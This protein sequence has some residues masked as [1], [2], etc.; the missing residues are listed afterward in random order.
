MSTPLPDSPAAERNK[1]PI[2]E[3]LRQ[4]LPASGAVLEIA[5]GTGQHVVHFAAAFPA[6]SWQ[7]TDPD[8][9]C[10]LAT[11]TRCDSAHLKNIHAP[12]QLDVHQATWPVADDFDAVLCINM[13]H[14][15]PWSATA[16]LLAGAARV[17]RGDGP[18]LVLLYG[19]YK[20]GGRHTAPSNEAFDASLRS[21]DPRWGVRDLE[22]VAEVAGSCGFALHAVHRLPANNLFV[23]LRGSA[24][25]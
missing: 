2:L 16:A 19:P 21:R 18:R 17:L 13:I 8:P 25:A 11:A 10:V 14:I 3:E 1:T 7:P 24:H 15:A 22:A 20:E 5:C 6:V 9:Q 12:L 4:L 23:V